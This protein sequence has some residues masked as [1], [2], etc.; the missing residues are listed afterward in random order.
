MDELET[1]S[2]YDPVLWDARLPANVLGGIN[3]AKSAERDSLGRFLPL[4][5][6][7]LRLWKLD[8]EHGKAGGRTR[9]IKAPR[10]CKGRFMNGI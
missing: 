3:R 6:P 5:P 8:A 4:D 1:I 9:A 10:D 2:I 7:A